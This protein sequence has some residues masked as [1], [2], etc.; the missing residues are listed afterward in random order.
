MDTKTAEFVS[1]QN[2]EKYERLLGTHLSEL[3]R[4]YV[5]ERLAA[6]RGF[7]ASLGRSAARSTVA[8]FS[9]IWSSAFDGMSIAFAS[10]ALAAPALGI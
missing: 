7:L 8:S 1:R 3:E 6:E 4:N 9:G 5:Q 10:I 2:I